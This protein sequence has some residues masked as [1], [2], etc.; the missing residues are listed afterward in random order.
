M[1]CIAAG[2]SQMDVM[3][4]EADLVDIES[5]GLPFIIGAKS[6]PAQPQLP[7]L[8]AAAKK[9]RA[10]VALVASE[11]QARC[12]PACACNAAHRLSQGFVHDEQHGEQY[13]ACAGSVAAVRYTAGVCARRGV[14][15]DR[16][17]A[18]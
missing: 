13:T 1:H 7:R 6:E 11:Q 9:A 15:G 16:R 10:F 12:L 4:A 5:A 14:G 2:R 18:R 8:R 17:R 3:F